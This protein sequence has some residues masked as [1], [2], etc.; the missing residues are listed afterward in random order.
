MVKQVVQ[1][2]NHTEYSILD[3]RTRVSELVGRAKELGQP[4]VAITD[5]GVMHGVMEFYKKAKNEG[6]KPIIGV[7]AYMAAGPMRRRD[8]KLDR[9]GSSFHLTLLARNEKGYRNLIKLVTKAHMEGFYYKPRLD[10]ECLSENRDGLL[11]LS[12]CLGSEVAQSVKNGDFESAERIIGAYRDIFGVDNYMLEIHDHGMEEQRRVNAWIL[13]AAKRFGLHVV[14]ACDSHYALP[15]DA[16]SHDALLAIQTGSKLDEGGRFRLDPYGQYYLK[17]ADEMYQTFS[18][19]EW[20]VENTMAIAEQ[21]VLDLD[22]SHIQ[23]PEFDIPDGQEENRWLQRKV[24]AGIKARFDTVTDEVI[25]RAKMELEII[26]KTGYARYF[27]IVED[28]VRHARSQG[29]MAVPRGSVAGSLCM[30]AL[31][32]CDIDPVKYDIMFERFLHEGR[33]GMPDVDMDFADDRRDDVIAYITEKYGRNRVA[34]IGT[35]QTLGTRAVVK[36][37]ARVM[38]VDFGE[39]NR[40]TRQLPPGSTV[41][42]AMETSEVQ[43]AIG[44]NP[45]MGEVMQIASQLEGIVRGFGTHAAG[46][47]IAATDLENVVPVQLPNGEKTAVTQWDNNNETAIIES[48]GLSKFDFLGLANLTVIREACRLI[49]ER[50][51]IDLYGTSGEKL[52]SQLPLEYG[53]P[54]AKRTYDMLASGETTAVFQLESPGMR[55]ALR[56]VKPT[57][58]TDLPAIVA[59]YRPGPMENIPVFAEAKHDRTKTPFF[60]DSI[61]PLLAETYGVVTY[62]DQVLLIARKMAGFSWGEVDVLRKGMGKKQASVIAEQEAKFMAGCIRNGYA[63]ETAQKVWDTLSPFA[64]Y[65]FNKA[66]AFCYGYVAYITAFLKAN[67]PV[68]YLCAVLTQEAGNKEKIEEAVVECKRLGLTVCVPDIN[69]SLREFSVIDDATILFGLSAVESL[70]DA[71]IRHIVANR[72]YRSLE[73][74]IM[75]VSVNSR[76]ATNLIKSGAMDQLGERKSLMELLPKVAEKRKSSVWSQLDLFGGEWEIEIPSVYPATDREKL[77]WE[78][79]VLGMY[80]SGHPLDHVRAKLARRV[81]HTS[82][83]LNGEWVTVGGLLVR[84]KGHYQK[85]GKAMLFVEMEDPHGKINAIAFASVF[86]QYRDLL[87]TDRIVVLTGRLSYRD[88]EPTVMITKVE[89]P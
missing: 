17:S 7:E 50:K 36:D 73:K 21:C 1:L 31:G 52:Y 56:L 58:I 65:G 23:L 74:F 12:G 10:L 75:T 85:N 78:K 42:S 11:V 87:M 45:V 67:F 34:H 83:N 38:G 6:I 46:M 13:D 80:I 53:N 33:K 43:D 16:R 27:L 66:H 9:A 22:F 14:A 19:A 69:T 84:T 64:G 62:Q 3:G 49:R 8:A 26:A 29:V 76:A 72:P 71:P 81:S 82:R 15:S 30:Y 88:D 48:I 5:H 44:D 28:Y 63:E 41:A 55:R 2:H 86:E 40:L 4:A 61:T 77:G 70:G 37:V 59:L 24:A 32:I 39:T 79:E 47:L 89:E 35:F 57:R 68:E 51:D 25:D 54:L 60:H 18:G 20:A